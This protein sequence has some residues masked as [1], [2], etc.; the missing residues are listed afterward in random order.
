MQVVCIF[1]PTGLVNARVMLMIMPKID[2][3]TTPNRHFV[4]M[5]TNP[6]LGNLNQNKKQRKK[7]E[8]NKNS[9]NIL[10]EDMGELKPYLHRLHHPPPV[11]PWRL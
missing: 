1:Y 3:R 11:I 4:V 6:K 7:G 2:V 10:D 5:K 8:T 9:T